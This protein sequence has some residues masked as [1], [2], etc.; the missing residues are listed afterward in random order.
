MR[1]ELVGYL[2]KQIAD[3]IKAS[4]DA[5]LKSKALT[6]SQMR[7]L[8]LASYHAEGIT[9]KAIEEH[10]QVSHPTI[11][12]IITRMEKNGYLECWMDPEDKRNKMVR[13]TPEAWPLAVEMRQE[14]EMQERRLL[15]GLSEEQIDGLYKAL[16]RILENVSK[17]DDTA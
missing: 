16:Y 15:E 1:R 2:L 4:A 14:I 5:S 3:K 6:L 8:E 7:V 10:F 17:K 13:L 12:G 9:Q 11:V